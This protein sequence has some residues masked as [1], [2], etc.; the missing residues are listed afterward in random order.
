MRDMVLEM[1]LPCV[2]FFSYYAYLLKVSFV[3]ISDFNVVTS[4]PPSTL[5]WR[6][7]VCLCQQKQLFAPANIFIVGCQSRV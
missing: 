3:V 5:P 1:H 6:I 7:N 4:P 2:Y